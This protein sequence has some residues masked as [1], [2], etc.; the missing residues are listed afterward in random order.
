ML[1]TRSQNVYLEDIFKSMRSW[2]IPLKD[3]TL[4]NDL[5]DVEAINFP[6]HLKE[7]SD[8]AV[9]NKTN[10]WKPV[11]TCTSFVYSAFIGPGHHQFLIYFP[12]R[13][14]INTQL[15]RT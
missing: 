3:K 4:K 7:Y 11:Q 8:L 15:N 9:N 12:E 2:A 6:E 10:E 1:A 14:I 5:V 13:I